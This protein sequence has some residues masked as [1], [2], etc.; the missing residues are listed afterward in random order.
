MCHILYERLL[1]H[2]ARI[3]TSAHDNCC[4]VSVV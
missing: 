3:T 4:I 2:T 1:R